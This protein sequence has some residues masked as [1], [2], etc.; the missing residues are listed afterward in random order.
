MVMVMV[1][2]WLQWIDYGAI[3]CDL[4]TS[5]VWANTSWGDCV[6]GN[7]NYAICKCWSKQRWLLK[8]LTNASKDRLTAAVL[9]NHLNH[10]A[11]KSIAKRKAGKLSCHCPTSL[12][13][14]WRTPFAWF[15]KFDNTD[16]AENSES[17][18]TDLDS[19]LPSLIFIFV[20]SI[21]ETAVVSLYMGGLIICRPS[22]QPKLAADHVSLWISSPTWVNWHLK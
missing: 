7:P 17:D 13:W 14:I 18:L 15:W 16:V 11:K 9:Y 2:K 20:W 22:A 6:F 4:H 21:S 19:Q 12:L 10:T 8:I 1:T 5:K 3:S